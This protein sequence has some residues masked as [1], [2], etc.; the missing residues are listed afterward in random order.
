MNKA[1]SRVNWQNEPSL[2][3]PLNATNLNKMDS[4]LDTVDTRVVTFDTTKANQSD[5]LQSLKQV[6]YNTTTGVFTFTYWNGTTQ[7]I[8]LNIEKIPVSFSMDANGV[9]T[10]TTADGTQYTADVSTLIKTY[11]FS[12]STEIDFTTTTDAS[13]NK[14]V[15][16]SLIN[17]SIAG[18]KLQPN[19]LADCVSAK[20]DAETAEGNAEQSARNAS[21]SELD[22]EA[23][24]LGT[25]NGTP[26]SSD[27]PAY[28]N[29]AKY[30][31]D[32]A[33][34]VP[35][36]PSDTTNLNMWIETV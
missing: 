6:A 21:S 30:Y 27:D 31:S 2:T 5:L 10:M 4:A 23:Y 20:N 9:I 11:T 19:Y 26:V 34:I 15:T 35:I 1:Y 12:D 29:N 36:D 17:G 7:D 8:D 14:T 13:G 16:A 28:H 22:S 33:Y 25:R 24:A 3:T 18:S 32:T